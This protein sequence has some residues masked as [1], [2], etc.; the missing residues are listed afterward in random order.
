MDE[1]KDIDNKIKETFNGLNK[2]APVDL[3]N[4][5]S[6]KLPTSDIDKTLEAK[7]KEGFEGTKQKAP[8]HIWGTVNKQLNIDK[9]W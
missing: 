1:N 8:E 3:W 5:F 4:K 9:V 7:V 6:D 2:S